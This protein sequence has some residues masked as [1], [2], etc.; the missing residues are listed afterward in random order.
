MSGYFSG[1]FYHATII[2]M[3]ICTAILGYCALPS[4]SAE[5]P[6]GFGTFMVTYLSAW[7]LCVAAD[8]LQ[9]PYVYALY[10]A[11]GFSKHEIA[12]LF[13]AGFGSA[14]VSSCFVGGLA[15]R[16]GRKKGCVAYCLLY[17]FSCATKHWKNYWVLMVG[18]V[19]GGFATSLL[20]SCF[21]CWMVSEHTVRNKFSSNLLSYMFGMKF[22]LMYLVAIMSGFMAQI[23][24]DSSPF[25]PVQGY[26][27]LYMGGN[28]VAFDMSAGVL[29]VALFVVCT[30]WSE[31]YGVDDSSDPEAET[32]EEGTSS[33]GGL[34]EA[35]NTLMGST[36]L[37]CLIAIVACFEGA[38]YAFVFNW[39][40]SLETPTERPPH[41]VVF[42]LMMMA[43]MRG[44]SR[45][46]NF[47]P[48]TG[49][50][51]SM[52]TLGMDR[53]CPER[54]LETGAEPRCGAGDV[55][56][57]NM[58]GVKLAQLPVQEYSTGRA[59]KNFLQHHVEVPPCRQ[60]LVEHDTE[61]QEDAPL[62]PA[63]G[64]GPR[65]VTLVVLDYR[66]D[67]T[68]HLLNAAEEGDSQKAS[69]L[70]R[71]LADPNGTEAE[72]WT[73][74]HIAAL[75]GHLEV[76]RTLLESLADVSRTNSDGGGA[77]HVAA[78]SGQLPMMKALCEAR[79]SPTSTQNEGWAPLHIASRHGHAPIVDFL[80][81]DLQLDPDVP[82]SAGWTAANI[83]TWA[84]HHE[85]LA[86]LNAHRGDHG[87]MG[88][89]SAAWQSMT[90]FMGFMALTGSG[91]S[92]GLTYSCTWGGR[93]QLSTMEEAFA[94][95][96][97]PPVLPRTLETE[98]DPSFDVV[99]RQMQVLHLQLRDIHEAALSRLAREK[100][101]SARTQSMESMERRLLFDGD[102]LE[103]NSFNES[104]RMRSFRE[105][106]EG[107][108]SG[109]L[110]RSLVTP[111]YRSSLPGSPDPVEAPKMSTASVSSRDLSPTTTMSRLMKR[112]RR[113]TNKIQDNVE[114]D[115][116]TNAFHLR[117]EWDFSDENLQALKRMQKRMGATMT[118]RSSPRTISAEH[119]L[120]KR[121]AA[122]VP[123]CYVMHPNA[124]MRMAWDI[125][126]I[127]AICLE[128]SVS[129]L[130]LYRLN[131]VEQKMADII[132][133]TLTSFWALDIV[134]SF[135]TASYV[136]DTLSFSLAHIAK[137]YL[138]SWFLFDITMLIPDL[139]AVALESDDGPLGIFRLLKVRRILRLL[140]F[141]QIVKA[142]RLLGGFRAQ[143]GPLAVPL[144]CATLVLMLA[145]H[146]LGSLW[147]AVG[148]TERGWVRAENLHTAVLGRQVSRSLE[149]ALSKLPS[150]SLRITVELE[151]AAER[152]LG[153]MGTG[154]SIVSGSIFV[155]FVTNTMANVMRSTMRTTQV[156][157]SAQKYCSLHGIPYSYSIQ[158][159]RYIERERRRF[160]LDS[161]MQLLQELPH[162]M[163]RELFQEVR[164]QTLHYHAF[165]RDVGL[166]NYFMEV[167]LCSEA[168]SEIYLLAGDVVFDVKKRARVC[169]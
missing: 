59:V 30:V 69:R 139:V 21:E 32:S 94:P 157:R 88:I 107:I 168:V 66:P 57:V 42:A 158:I 117:E 122:A 136:N 167:D 112:A 145:V 111:R 56:V 141:V 137:N 8:W 17:I 119:Y 154:I 138:K 146:V 143:I 135:F 144:L 29:L 71:E 96:E 155:S 126:A 49:P 140:R 106:P 43:C 89:F 74:L 50:S 10:E 46:P 45:A 14:M 64:D 95:E 68:V 47:W 78:W 102:A 67:L 33:K 80:L 39:T 150:S 26:P 81:T 5:W 75:N 34:V 124:R 28:T 72:G 77:L 149:W 128:I 58:A 162:G 90:N 129:P 91:G 9:G 152:W 125:L 40:P 13:V 4:R 98:P 37:T 36:S 134:A 161:H 73:P 41:G 101:K 118:Q 108:D 35:W 92:S 109:A 99:F 23:G 53:Q 116:D 115:E 160:E 38:M 127:A 7:T 2:P 151:T 123:P 105:A 133:W 142:R 11:Y 31:N 93:R 147:F 22:T 165:F 48:T 110:S 55:V 97:E 120:V 15:D 113:A 156:L 86:L 159:K 27:V 16:F 54:W 6:K 70:L 60:R 63:C 132:N 3:S 169:T 1:S 44:S 24:V 121:M 83:A 61:L 84:E 148:D 12:E 130:F 153:I 25:Q 163:V 18:R 103:P 62:L 65:C 131:P 19:T 164:S 76:A 79:A 82:V 52:G 87:E 114:A 85:V 51:W 166:N 100:I 20:F 104:N